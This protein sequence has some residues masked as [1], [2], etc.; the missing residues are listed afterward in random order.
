MNIN[1]EVFRDEYLKLDDMDRQVFENISYY[2][3]MLISLFNGVT[4]ARLKHCSRFYAA[5]MILRLYQDK[6]K[7]VQCAEKF[8]VQKEVLRDICKNVLSEL[9]RLK[10]AAAYLQEMAALR[11]PVNDLLGILE[12]YRKAYFGVYHNSPN[13]EVNKAFRNLCR[14]YHPD[15]AGGSHNKF[16]EMQYYMAVI[17]AAK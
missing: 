15:K 7:D 1:A 5:M 4:P 17:K 2:N 9:K 6:M 12:K 3:K 10:R 16:T 14:K 13:V 11:K 8:D